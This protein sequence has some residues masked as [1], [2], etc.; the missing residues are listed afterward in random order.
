M[1]QVKFVEG[2]LYKNN[3]RFLAINYIRKTLELKCLAVK[4]YCK[5]YQTYKMKRFA[6]T[7]NEAVTSFFQTLDLR[8]LTGF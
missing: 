3:S 6:K 5:P 1:N 4:E 8:C 7:V 2:R